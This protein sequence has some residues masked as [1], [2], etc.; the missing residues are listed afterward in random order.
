MERAFVYGD[1]LIETMILDNGF[2][3]YQED[4]L[5]RLNAGM[6]Y[7]QMNGKLNLDQFGKM[8][9]C[10]MPGESSRRVRLLA[11]R[12]ADGLY[13]PDSN[14]VVYEVEHRPFENPKQQI[15]QIGFYRSNYKACCPLSAF[16]TGNALI[17]ILALK[18]AELKNWDDVLIVNEF[19]RV[20]EASSSN[21]FIIKDQRVITPPL[22]EGCVM[23][24]MRAVLLRKMAEAGI[25][26]F[27]QPVLPDD[28]ES[29]DELFL[30]NAV[31]QVVSVE[32]YGTKT[33]MQTQTNRIRMLL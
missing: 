10:A 23:G 16:K 24:V 6:E 27:E 1:L 20:C 4:H 25:D 7:L 28:I 12:N 32:R 17:Y 15:E 29:A 14:E 13:K 21:V 18:E 22:S 19:G 9:H 31:H 8:I 3:R 33:Y 5:H 26:F 2:I 30:T 11:Y